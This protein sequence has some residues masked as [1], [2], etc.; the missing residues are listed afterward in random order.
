MKVEGAE[1]ISAISHFCAAQ[2]MLAAGFNACSKVQFTVCRLD[3]DE[4]KVSE[5][6]FATDAPSWSL[7]VFAGESAIFEPRSCSKGCRHASAYK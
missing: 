5:A 2:L 3:L 4:F 1:C 7:D 6:T